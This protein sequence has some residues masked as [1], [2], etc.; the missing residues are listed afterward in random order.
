MKPTGRERILDIG[1]GL[2][3]LTRTMARATR[4]G[5]T[6]V[7]VERDA[8]QIREALRQAEQAGESDI[9]ELREGDATD[10]PLAPDE[11][12]SFDVVHSRFLL[13]HLSDPL[14]AV[15]QMASAARIGGRVILQDDDHDVMRFWP[16][17]DDLSTVWHAYARVRVARNG[18]LYRAQASAAS[19]PSRARSH[20]HNLVVLRGVCRQ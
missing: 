12:G 8:A 1:S 17:L 9:I 10:L 14:V 11:W 15:N 2:A 6:V 3:Q 7:G 13:E 20:L 18:R 19:P 5:P 16:P 4:N